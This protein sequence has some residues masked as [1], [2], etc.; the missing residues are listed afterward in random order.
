LTWGW[1]QES[2]KERQWYW[3]SILY[4]DGPEAAAVL[5]DRLFEPLRRPT[6][7]LPLQSRPF[8]TRSDAERALVDAWREARAEG[9]QPEE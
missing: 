6:V 5:P 9:W 3:L 8:A 4:A 1:E 2:A 7:D